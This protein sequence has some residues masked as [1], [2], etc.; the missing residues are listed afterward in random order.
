M[1][2]VEMC[3]TLTDQMSAII[4][5]LIPSEGDNDIRALVALMLATSCGRRAGYDEEQLVALLRE[6]NAA[7]AIAA[8]MIKADATKPKSS[9]KKR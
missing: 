2:R 9:K 6:A 5:R 3:L 1:N 4:E 7:T 8:A